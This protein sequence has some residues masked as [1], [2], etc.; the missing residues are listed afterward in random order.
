MARPIRD[1]QPDE[2]L[3]IAI[4][5]EARNAERYDTF[6]HIFE[7]YNDDA[8][9]LFAEMRDEELEHRNVLQAMYHSRY[10]DRPS[11]LDEADVDEVV[12]AVD[13]D[14]A[15]HMVFNSLTRREVLEAAL[16]AEEGARQFYGALSETVQDEELLELYRRLGAF[17]EGHVAAIKMR[18][19]QADAVKGAEG[20]V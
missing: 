5:V 7:S 18:I 4:A 17:E 19:N 9:G 16:R 10:G 14:D 1:L 11:V 20:D 15:E 3:S 12:E 8:S 13:V 6:A 2:V